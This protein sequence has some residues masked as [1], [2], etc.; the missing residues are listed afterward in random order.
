VA[1]PS[2]GHL[3]ARSAE[4]PCDAAQPKPAGGRV[5][6]AAPAAR[7]SGVSPGMPGGSGV[8]PGMKDHGSAMST[9]FLIIAALVCGVVILAASAIQILLAR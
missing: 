7:G 1:L 9:R 8:S 5:R 3:S 6:H 2:A 4:L